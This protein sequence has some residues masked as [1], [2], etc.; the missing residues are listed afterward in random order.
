MAEQY[1]RPRGSNRFQTLS[2]QNSKLPS[3]ELDQELNLLYRIVNA[4]ETAGS[5]NL[6]CWSVFNGTFTYS[7]DDEITVSGDFSTYFYVL[8]PIRSYDSTNGY[9]Y[10]Y[11]KSVSY[12][13]G[14]DVTVITTF[15]NIFFSTTEDIYVGFLDTEAIN[16]SSTSG[17]IITSNKTVAYTDKVFLCDDTNATSQM[18]A[19]D[20]DGETASIASILITLPPASDYEGR[21]LTIKKTAGTNQVI[22]SSPL[23]PR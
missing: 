20:D 21:I 8:R 10:S 13:A 9:K 1:T 22:V 23:L 12:N 18:W 7:D 4:L 2:A 17:E 3:S 16:L 19:D 14:L 5:L 11:V 6:D 15:S